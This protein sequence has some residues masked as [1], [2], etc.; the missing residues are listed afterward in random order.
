MGDE[1]S[2]IS[3]PPPNIFSNILSN[4]MAMQHGGEEGRRIVTFGW[5]RGETYRNL[6]LAKMVIEKKTLKI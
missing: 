6:W 2:T 3:Y 5:R 4:Q 1:E